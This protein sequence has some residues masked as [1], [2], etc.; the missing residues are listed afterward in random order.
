LIFTAYDN[1]HRANAFL[2]WIKDANFENIEV[3]KVGHLVGSGKK[4]VK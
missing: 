4:T 2:N 3:L 1:P